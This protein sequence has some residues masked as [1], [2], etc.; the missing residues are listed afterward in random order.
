MPECGIIPATKLACMSFFDRVFGKKGD[1]LQPR[2]RGKSFVPSIPEQDDAAAKY[3]LGNELHQ[4]GDL[5]A[6]VALY[7]EAIRLSPDLLEARNNLANTLYR[8][9]DLNSA[10]TEFRELIRLAPNFADAHN[11]LGNVLYAT[12]D[13]DAAM[14][15]Y[16]EAIRLKPQSSTAQ[17]ARENLERAA[18]KREVEQ[19]RAVGQLVTHVHSNHRVKAQHVSLG[20]PSPDELLQGIPQLMESCAHALES[21]RDE[22]GNPTSRSYMANFFDTLPYLSSDKQSTWLSYVQR[23]LT[24]DGV[25][26]LRVG[27]NELS[28][29]TNSLRLPLDKAADVQLNLAGRPN[30]P[31]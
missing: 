31:S 6:A 11:N 8:M 24:P 4:K 23:V 13:V 27:L 17:A 26:L 30:K 18:L 3:H 28:A 15:E 22:G 1:R 19:L 29:A 9:G 2:G 5:S 20:G 12:D 10:T 14:R 16:R 21:G 25:N 7:R